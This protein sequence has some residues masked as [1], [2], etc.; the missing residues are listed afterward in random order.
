[1]SVVKKICR[2]CGKEYEPCRTA[3]RVPGVFHWQE[4]ACSAE[5]GAIYLRRVNESRI[6]A[7]P[8]PEKPGKKAASAKKTVAAPSAAKAAAETVREAGNI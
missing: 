8:L 1:M 6:N 4:V 7:E 2:V 5:C 3:R